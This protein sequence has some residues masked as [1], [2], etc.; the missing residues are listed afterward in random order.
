VAR[1]SK[2]N[3]IMD[4]LDMPVNGRGLLASDEFGLNGNAA[5]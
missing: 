3:G 5:T 2:L 4:L 1:S